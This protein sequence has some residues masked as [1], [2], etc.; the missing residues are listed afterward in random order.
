MAQEA[1]IPVFGMMQVG[2]SAVD[3]RA[4]EIQRERGALIAAQQQFRIRFALRG[5]EARPIDVVAAIA[6]QRHAVARFGVGRTRLGVLAGE[7]ADANHRL[8][9]AL[10]QHQ[11]HLQQDLQAPR[12]VVRFAVLEAL[13]AIAALQQ[14][15]LAALRQRELRAQRLDLPGDHQRRQRLKAATARSSASGSAYAAAGPQRRLASSRVPVRQNS[16]GLWT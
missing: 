13:G 2:E 3:Q 8:L 10:Q 12:D 9:Q 5:R 14:K 6:R 16:V 7:A 4:H 15:L 11:A 1:K